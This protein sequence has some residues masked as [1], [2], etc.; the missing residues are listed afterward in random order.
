MV[1]VS[2]II[3][4][5]NMEKYL[6]RCLDSVEGQTF[7]DWEIICINDGST[8]N[9]AI[10]LDEYKSRDPRI[11]VL[12]NKVNKGLSYS[13]NIGIK[14]AVG[15][16]IFFLDADD[17]IKLE[18][19]EELFRE[20]SLNSLDILYFD[21]QRRFENKE[22]C[23]QFRDYPDKRK[24]A[25][26]NIYSGAKLFELFHRNHDHVVLSTNFL[27]R[28]DF[29]RQNKIFFYENIM[30]EDMLFFLQ[31]IL[32]AKR[33]SCVAKVYYYYEIHQHSIMTTE[34]NRKILH[35]FK[36]LLMIYCEIYF[37]Y[38]EDTDDLKKELEVAVKDYAQI[39]YE[40]MV[41]LFFQLRFNQ[42][43][44]MVFPKGFQN[45]F[46]QLFFR[47]HYK[48]LVY[49]L[50]VKEIADIRN[51]TIVIL[52]GAGN[53]G[54]EI[55]E[56]LAKQHID[57]FVFAVTDKKEEK[58]IGGVPIY[59]IHE[60]LPLKQE[61]LVLITVSKIYQ[62]EIYDTLKKLQFKNVKTIVRQ[63]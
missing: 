45:A 56:I 38:L 32:V 35:R 46:Y 59:D 62:Q 18:S 16:Y 24:Y 31:T 1:A 61:A 4:I 20:A 60:L 47:E 2:I 57:D 51:Y 22:L 7:S 39:I 28:R 17:H 36:S 23:E 21:I 42:A 29:L 43:S 19:I 6:S 52:Y 3:P 50:N 8:D 27:I 15:E 48:P 34:D 14:N 54:R 37:R 40:S 58:K 53:V 26:P 49:G 30:H 63:E 33:V 25:Y 41:P 13:R 44:T 11:K 55:A 9:S 12:E 5:Y 10:I